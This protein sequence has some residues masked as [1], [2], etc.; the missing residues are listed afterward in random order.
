M[1]NIYVFGVKTGGCSYGVIRDASLNGDVQG[2]AVDGFVL[3]EEDGR[4]KF[5][6]IAQHFS[7]GE[8]FCKHDMGITSNW[9]HEIYDKLYPDG[10]ELKW[11]GVFDNTETTWEDIKSAVANYEN[12]SE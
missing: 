6:C 8:G 10:Y 4:N 7:T 11:L 1:K 3:D 2:Y 9:K 5:N 12:K